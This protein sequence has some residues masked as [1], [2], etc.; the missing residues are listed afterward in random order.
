MKI[1]RICVIRTRTCTRIFRYPCVLRKR[2]LCLGHAAGF[3][4]AQKTHTYWKGEFYVLLVFQRKCNANSE[5][6]LLKG[7]NQVFIF[8]NCSIKLCRICYFQSPCQHFAVQCH[9][10]FNCISVNLRCASALFPHR[11]VAGIHAYGG[12]AKSDL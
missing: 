12:A 3:C 2:K 6:L 5:I 7:C 10:T 8:K 1:K 4:S 11:S 9:D